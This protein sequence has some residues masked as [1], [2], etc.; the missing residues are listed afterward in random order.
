MAEEKKKINT[1]QITT[2]VYIANATSLNRKLGTHTTLRVLP[3]KI[4]TLL[5][6]FEHFIRNSR[7]H[8][9]CP[10]LDISGFIRINN[11]HFDILTPLLSEPAA[12]GIHTVFDTGRSILK[13]IE[14]NDRIK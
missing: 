4:S 14:T 12:C 2:I 11:A 5:C 9:K 13:R 3:V 10:Y 6:T 7:F 8:R 1:L